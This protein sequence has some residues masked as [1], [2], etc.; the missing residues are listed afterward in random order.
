MS[1]LI[2]GTRKITQ[3]TKLLTKI[4]KFSGLQELSN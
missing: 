4:P 1:K 3:I 2:T